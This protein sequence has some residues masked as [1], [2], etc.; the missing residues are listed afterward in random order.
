MQESDGSEF[1]HACQPPCTSTA[2]SSHSPGSLSVPTHTP[3]PRSFLELALLF[4]GLASTHSL[5]PNLSCSGPRIC[6]PSH[7]STGNPPVDGPVTS[8]LAHVCFQLLVE[9]AAAPWHTQAFWVELRPASTDT[10]RPRGNKIVSA[11]TQLLH[12]LHTGRLLAG[13]IAGTTR[14]VSAVAVLQR[15]RWGGTHSFSSE[16]DSVLECRALLVWASLPFSWMLLPFCDGLGCP[17]MSGPSIGLGSAAVS[18]HCLGECA[19]ILALRGSAGTANQQPTRADCLKVCW[20]VPRALACVG[21]LKG[22]WGE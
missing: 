20:A 16:K 11:A 15:Q 7:H 14:S 8:M 22:G 9:A 5:T 6:C 2:C 17:V 10:S 3:L 21:R 4:L 13:Y 12:T 19:V 1:R 18:N